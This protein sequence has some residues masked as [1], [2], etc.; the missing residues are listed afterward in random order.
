MAY[1]TPTVERFRA[2]LARHELTQ[3]EAA[4][5]AHIGGGNAIRK[6]TGGAKPHAATHSLM[7]ALSAYGLFARR[8]EATIE[9]QRYD[10]A[11]G[12]ADVNKETDTASPWHYWLAIEAETS[13]TDEMMEAIAADLVI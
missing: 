6:F 12:L 9:R 10:E 5:A 2:M 7:F 13:F 11:A 8:P 3:A 1:H 4:R